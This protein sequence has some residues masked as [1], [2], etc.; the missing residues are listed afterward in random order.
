MKNEVVEIV[1]IELTDQPGKKFVVRRT[2]KGLFFS[3]VDYRWKYPNPHWEK[4]QGRYFKNCLH[5]TLE[6]AIITYKSLTSTFNVFK[7]ERVIPG[8]ELLI[9]DKS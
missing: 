2:R 8:L 3:T 4:R 7:T 1:E 5:D 9:K 6:D